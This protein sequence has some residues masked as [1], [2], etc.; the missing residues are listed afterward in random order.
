MFKLGYQVFILM[1]ML[2]GFTITLVSGAKN[3]WKKILFLAGVLP[4]LF[5]VSI[6]PNFAVRS[7]FEELRNYRGLYG[8]N[9]M[10]TRYSADL[11]AIDWL[12]TNIPDGQQPVILEAS[13]D[14]YTEYTRISTFTGLPTVAGWVV[15]EWLWRGSYE[16][17]AA[18]AEEVT[19][20]ASH[21]HGVGQQKQRPKNDR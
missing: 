14:S 17:I 8:L 2:A 3:S 16:P 20:I 9:W 12:N 21:Q 10:Q 7:Y 11:A 19:Q 5:L 6:Y 4:M 13:G 1:S 18:R 15:H